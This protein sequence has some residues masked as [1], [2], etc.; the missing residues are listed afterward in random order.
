MS[1]FKVPLGLIKIKLKKGIVYGSR[2]VLLP[3]N[4]PSLNI[5]FYRA[6]GQ[7]KYK[8]WIKY[9]ET[10]TGRRSSSVFRW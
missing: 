10:R 4:R 6:V 5:F 7:G 9:Y 2:C 8:Q 1:Y 3:K